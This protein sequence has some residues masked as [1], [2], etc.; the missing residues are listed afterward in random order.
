MELWTYQMLHLQRQITDVTILLMREFF[1][2]SNTIG[3]L[4]VKNKLFL[5]QMNV[6][7]SYVSKFGEIPGVTDLFCEHAQ[8]IE[9]Q[10]SE[11]GDDDE[12][13]CH[14]IMI[15]KSAYGLIEDIMASKNKHSEERT[16]DLIFKMEANRKKVQSIFQSHTNN[17]CKATIYLKK[18]L[19]K[20]EA[21]SEVT[22]FS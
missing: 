11:Q 10:H 4:K 16:T 17:C 1:H 7:A 20:E 19:P 22:A 3:L 21:F 2:R 5:S 12:A 6:Y 18:L 8:T 14:N 13:V 9:M 15:L